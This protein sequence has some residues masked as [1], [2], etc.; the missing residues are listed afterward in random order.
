MFLA[1]LVFPP[2]CSVV[3]FHTSMLACAAP[4]SGIPLYCTWQT[5]ITSKSCSNS[6]TSWDLSH[7]GTLG[8]HTPTKPTTLTLSFTYTWHLRLLLGLLPCTV[9]HYNSLVMC[10][11]LM[12]DC[13]LPESRTVYFPSV[14]WNLE[15]CLVHPGHQISGYQTKLNWMETFR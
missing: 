6:S 5:P 4:L 13:V 11:T 15:L 9:M 8:T 14:S 12:L 2:L 1:L 3:L 10:L 7:L